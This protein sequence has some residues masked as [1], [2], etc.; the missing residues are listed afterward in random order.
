MKFRWKNRYLFYSALMFA[1]F[2][3]IVASLASRIFYVIDSGQAGVLYRLLWGTDTKNVYQ[4][5]IVVVFPWNR[6]FIYDI[7][8]QE[9]TRT[10]QVLSF[11]GLNIEVVFSFRY[12]PDA[13]KLPILHQ[14]LGQNYV[15]KIVDPLLIS[16][17]REVIGNYRPEELY[18]THAAT[19]QQE[20]QRLCQRSIEEYNIRFSQVLIQDINLPEKVTIAI[21][22]KLVLQQEAES[23]DFRLMSTERERLRK[24]VEAEGIR[25]YNRIIS[26]ELSEGLLQYQHIQALRDLSTS[27]NTK[28]LVLEGGSHQPVTLPLYLNSDSPSSPPSSAENTRTPKAASPSKSA[29]TDGQTETASSTS[30]QG[31]ASATHPDETTARPSSSPSGPNAPTG[32]SP[33]RTHGSGDGKAKAEATSSPGK[34]DK[35]SPATGRPTPPEKDPKGSPDSKRRGGTSP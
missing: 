2:L 31:V 12:R 9:L 34:P 10:V 5:G 7:R 27:Q 29:P 13:E 32:S 28:V 17:V 35:K 30:D 20:I 3:F 19:I 33:D 24:T 22:D 8:E 6:V 26:E 23:Y 16:A 25:Q 21:E 18:T 14:Q 15:E 1:I 4:E 11:N